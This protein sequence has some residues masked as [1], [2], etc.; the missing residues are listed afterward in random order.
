MPEKSCSNDSTALPNQS[1]EEQHRRPSNACSSRHL[2]GNTIVNKTYSEVLCLYEH[3]HQH[4]CIYGGL[5][6]HHVTMQLA[7][8]TAGG[9]S[10]CIGTSGE[11]ERLEK[12]LPIYQVQMHL[13]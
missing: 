13:Q 4:Y 8:D 10:S 3:P 6:N 1:K 12:L 5:T 2:Q 7:E 9:T 11:L